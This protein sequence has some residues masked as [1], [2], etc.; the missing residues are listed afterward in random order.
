MARTVT[1]TPE[2]GELFRLPETST[3]ISYSVSVSV[4]DDG[5]P[6][7]SVTGYAATITPEQSIL[8]VSTAGSVTVSADSLAGL[9]P[10]QFID[11]LLNGVPGRVF[12]WE[13]LPA[14]AEDII[15]FRP[16]SGVSVTF[17]MVVIATLSDASQVQA[18]YTMTVTQDWTAGRDRLVMEVNARR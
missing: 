11:F 6:D 2:P 16:G 3:D 1:W 12:S 17:T 8:D 9:F 5:D 18:T 10:I 15:E 7:L 13:D 14:E 4:T